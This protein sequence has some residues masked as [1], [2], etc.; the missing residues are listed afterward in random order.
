[1]FHVLL[2]LFLVLLFLTLEAVRQKHP[3]KD[4]ERNDFYDCML[5]LGAASSLAYLIGSA[6]V[7]ARSLGWW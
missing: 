3:P 2:A 1:M 6:L 5:W 7:L 4:P